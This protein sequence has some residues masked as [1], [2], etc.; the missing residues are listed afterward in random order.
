MTLRAARDWP[1]VGR[2][3]ELEELKKSI[4]DGDC[5]GVIIAGPSGVGK[6]RVALEC[7]AIAGKL[8]FATARVP[9]TQPLSN[10]PFGSIAL[11]PSYEPADSTPNLQRADLVRQAAAAL[12][13]GAQGRRLVMLV[14]DA[15]FLDTMSAAVIQQLAVTRAAFVLA[16]ERSGMSSPGPIVALWKDR[17][18]DRTEL[19]PLE[20]KSLAKLLEQVLGGQVDPA[21]VGTLSRRSQGNMLFLRELV[22]GAL[23]SGTLVQDMGV[24]RLSGLVTP[25]DRLVGLVEARLRGL[26]SEE[27]ELLELMSIVEPL[28]TAELAALSHADIAESLEAKGL[29]VSYAEG[30]RVALKFAHPLYGD[31][32]R[33]RMPELRR[34]RLAKSMAD[35]FES[36]AAR[37]RE[38]LLRIATLRL[39]SGGGD[40]STML[41]AAREA[42]W[43]YDFP[44]AERLARQAHELGAGF[45][46]RLLTAQVVGLQGRA[47]EADNILVALAADADTDAERGE[48]AI[49]RL[50]HALWGPDPSTGEGIADEAMAQISDPQWRVEVAGR[51]VALLG[52]LRGPNESVAAAKELVDTTTGRGLAKACMTMAIGLARQGLADASLAA[53]ERGLREQLALAEPLDVYPYIY[54]MNRC[55][56]LAAAGLLHEYEAHA[57]RKY[58]EALKEG[59]IEQQAFFSWYVAR[60]SMER[61][62]VNTAAQHAREAVALFHEIDRPLWM[63]C[64]LGL[65]AAATALGGEAS[66]SVAISDQFTNLPCAA[67][68]YMATDM[69]RAQ[70]WAAIADGRESHARAKLEEAAELGER[71]GDRLGAAYALHDLVRLG[72]PKNVCDRLDALAAVIDGELVGTMA[73]HAHAL[74]SNRPD[75]LES[76]SRQFERLG[77]DLL[78]ADAAAQAAIGWSDA[79]ERRRAAAA[80]RR[81]AVLLERCEGAKT[82]ATLTVGDAALLSPA[83][84]DTAVLAAAGRSNKAIA[85]ELFVSVRTVETRLNHVYLKLGIAG[86][87]ELAAVFRT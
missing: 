25:P 16:T 43:H 2:D 44:L 41:A 7:L 84:R 71:I 51:H 59:S 14:D 65:L 8:G 87:Q 85:E 10:V 28:G 20:N 18:L 52:L 74:R 30:S 3:D 83:E 60:S 63:R 57:R 81:V 32:L 47:A 1:I 21:A 80:D 70:A 6:T 45:E 37:T 73:A 66:E 12:V 56:A 48:V 61:G 33:A 53:S 4:M 15:Q 49:V 31:V 54:D 19:R 69:L 72:R 58:D 75:D 86:R 76:V 68:L 36:S 27:R 5:A 11:F 17:V 34:Q 79:G 46:A 77:A 82:P 50:D 9:A 22:I 40:P 13:D 67:T 55:E 24:W 64:S 42:R 78:A 26:Q 39:V 23:E 29:V 62:R 38:D 35:L